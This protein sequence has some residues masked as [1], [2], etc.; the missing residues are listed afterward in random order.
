MIWNIDSAHTGI[1]MSR[2]FKNRYSHGQETGDGSVSCF[3]SENQTHNRPLSA[4]VRRTVPCPKTACKMLWFG[5]FTYESRNRSPFRLLR[6]SIHRFITGGKLLV[7][8]KWQTQIR[9]GAHFICSETISA[10]NRRK[11][12]AELGRRT[13]GNG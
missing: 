4:P 12:I 10:S 8:T 11:N 6:M 7:N 9:A 13:F 5:N 1:L 2:H 3:L